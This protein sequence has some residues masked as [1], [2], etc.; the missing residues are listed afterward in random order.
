[1]PFQILLGDINKVP[2][3]AIVHPVSGNIKN[4]LEVRIHPLRVNM[5][6]S[7]YDEVIKV[8]IGQNSLLP[9]GQHNF[10]YVIKAPFPYSDDGYND[11]ETVLRHCYQSALRIVRDFNLKEVAF[12]LVGSEERGISKELALQIAT[13]E[14]R[15][16]LKKYEEASILLVVRD[17]R[18]FLPDSRMLVN[19]KPQVPTV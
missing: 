17:K 12:P 13:D 5:K 4:E 15:Q 10:Q 8:I 19:G 6:N 3:E 14:I 2:T 7:D 11:P 9:A 18:S 1:M 16:F